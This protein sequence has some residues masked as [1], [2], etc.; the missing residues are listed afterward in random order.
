MSTPMIAPES[1]ATPLRIGYEQ[2]SAEA[3]LAQPD[4]LAIIGF[5]HARKACV[6]PRVLR[7]GL[8]PLQEDLLEVWRCALMVWRPKAN[9][10]S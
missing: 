3:L 10:C 6:D 1:P 7:V 5:G 8:E 2:T 4:V 9:H